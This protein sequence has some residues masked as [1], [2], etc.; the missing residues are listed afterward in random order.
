MKVAAQ[1]FAE[2][3]F[4]AFWTRLLITVTYDKIAEPIDLS[5]A[6]LITQQNVPVLKGSLGLSLPVD[7]AF[8]PRVG[9]NRLADP[10]VMI[11]VD[12]YTTLDGFDVG[13]SGK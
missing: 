2:L 6:G 5:F 10:S 1:I 4:A 12:K 9:G 13:L 3:I 8:S 11:G 7:H